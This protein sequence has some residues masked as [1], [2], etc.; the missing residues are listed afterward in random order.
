M[1]EGYTSLINTLRYYGRIVNGKIVENGTQIPFNF[2]I[3]S[4]SKLQV[5]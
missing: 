2:L 5:I 3:M 1:A 4:N